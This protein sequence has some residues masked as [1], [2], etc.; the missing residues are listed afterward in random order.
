MMRSM[1]TLMLA[2]L[3]VMP[4]AAAPP[5]M[6]GLSAAEQDGLLHELVWANVA[7]VNCP[8]H[9]STDSEWRFVVDAADQLAEHLGL[10]TGA[11]D[12]DY[13]K[14]A[15]DAIDDDP[16]FCAVEGPKILPLIDRLVEMGGRVDK[17]KIRG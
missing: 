7:G 1:L 17:Y 4:A 16:S 12:D 15:F 9:M 13:Y 3:L 2:A 5:D 6:S 11:Y 14:P 10:D 8:D